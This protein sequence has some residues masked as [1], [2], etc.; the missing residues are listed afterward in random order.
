MNITLVLPDF[1][2]EATVNNIFSHCLTPDV[3]RNPMMKT[4]TKNSFGEIKSKSA[5]G[6]EKRLSTLECIVYTILEDVQA[7][8][9]ST[10]EDLSKAFDG[11][12]NDKENFNLLERLSNLFK[13]PKA[14]ENIENGLQTL[15]VELFEIL[16][17][18][19]GTI[20]DSLEIDEVD[21][22]LLKDFSEEA[23][24]FS[25]YAY[26][27]NKEN[28]IDEVYNQFTKWQKATDRHLDLH[29]LA[30]RAIDAFN[31]NV[32]ADLRRIDGVLNDS[33]H[34]SCSSVASDAIASDFFHI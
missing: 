23:S 20:N 14:T 27:L 29:H 28:N 25:Q 7:I 24:D 15:D 16:K 31:V 10:I 6:V 32:S 8:D 2:T 4:N 13:D 22:S 1:I 5:A 9:F 26:G 34:N 21:F 33:C 19:A 3:P 11:A 30:I 12:N 18:F 17:K